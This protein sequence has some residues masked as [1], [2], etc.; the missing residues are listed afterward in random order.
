[1]LSRHI[2]AFVQLAS[3]LRPD[4]FQEEQAN[5]LWFVFLLDTQSCLTGNDD[6]GHCVR[7]YLADRSFLPDS[8]QLQHLRSGSASDGASKLCIAVYDLP[9]YMSR[10]LAELSQLA[11]EMRREAKE[12]RGSI[13]SRRRRI[14]SFHHIL[15]SEWTSRYEDIL[16]QMSSEPDSGSDQS[17]SIILECVS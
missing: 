1:M 12:Q 9:L 10:K 15:Y 8:A 14:D 13:A 16:A 4:G 3:R 5:M 6:A 11:L 17:L 2:K 7:A